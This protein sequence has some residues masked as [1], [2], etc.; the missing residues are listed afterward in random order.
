MV[1]SDGILKFIKRGKV[2]GTTIDFSELV[3][4]DDSSE[5]LTITRIQELELPRQVDVIYLNRNA[6]YQAGT[7]SSQRQT[8]KAVDYSTINLPIVLSDQEAKVVADVTLYIP[9]SC[10]ELVLHG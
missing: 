7:Q 3:A 4:E 6:D 5:T 8:V 2:S 9:L 10:E 1:E